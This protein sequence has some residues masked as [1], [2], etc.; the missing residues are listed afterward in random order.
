M[1]AVAAAAL[2]WKPAAEAG[3]P[4]QEAQPEAAKSEA[5]RIITETLPGAVAGDPYRVRLRAAG[6]R[7]PY[8][9]RLQTGGLPRSLALDPASGD[10]SGIPALDDLQSFTV[11]V[12]DSSS[13]P[14]TAARVFHLRIA[15][16][17]VLWREPQSLPG[18]FVGAPYK[19][20]F[21]ALGGRAPLKW[22]IASGALPSG[23]V[24]NPDTG[25]LEGT[26]TA[27][28]EFRFTV[29]VRDASDPRQAQTRAFITRFIRPLAV[30]WIGAPHLESSGIRGSVRVWNGS[31]TPLEVT[32]IVV[33]VNEYGK[34]FTL[35]YEKLPLGSQRYS[36]EIPFGTSLPRGRY[37]VHADAVGEF[38]PQTILRDRLQ[39]GP[40]RVD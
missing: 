38:P 21:R 31:Y 17:L 8:T 24:L 36:P 9:W 13:P 7:A 32:V 39:Q 3:H 2:V 26:P 25:V 20:E 18:A 23:L 14:K 22:D 35:G 27:E 4:P 33:A 19:A 5:V 37:E 34:A 12:A 1:L 10:I 16:R 11:Q 28:G 6:G 29:R 40:F 30:V 15:P